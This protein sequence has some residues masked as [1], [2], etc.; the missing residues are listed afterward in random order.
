MDAAR[1]PDVI[2]VPPGDWHCGPAVLAG[3]L[4]L[5]LEKGARLIAPE[6]LEAYLPAERLIRKKRS[7]THFFLGALGAENVVIEGEGRI[8]LGGHRFWSDWDGRPWTN[9]GLERGEDGFF[10]EKLYKPRPFR[11]VGL[12]LENCRNVKISGITL[13]DSAAYTVWALGCDDLE[14]ERIA[15]CNDRRGPNT[16]GLDIDGCRN[17]RIADCRISGGDDCIALKSDRD[18]LG[19]ER[20]CEHIR[21][22]G[23]TLSSHTCGVRLGY[24]GDNII[25]DVAAHDNVIC[26]SNVGFDLLSVIPAGHVVGIMR[27]TPIEN[28]DLSG[29]VMRNVRMPFKI[30]SGAVDPADGPA[31]AGFVRN[32]R[33]ADM[34]I[35]ATDSCFLGGAA[36]SDIALSDLNI[37]VVRDPRGCLGAEP[38]EMPT[39]WGRGYL[40]EALTFRGVRDLK[41]TDVNVT[42]TYSG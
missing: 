2:V 14:I 17:V 15:I 26:D 42:E 1:G 40:P 36:V 25:R 35:D 29:A 27:G 33:F 7:Q 13:C 11:P 18:L 28:V 3:G 9:A 10:K 32:V 34:E 20:P 24:E 8:E 30:W 4:T 19:E 6:R 41:L 23:C 22:S 12:W 21:I 38:V 31:Y 39:L 37:R 5:H 16:D